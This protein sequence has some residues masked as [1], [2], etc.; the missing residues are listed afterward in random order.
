MFFVVSSTLTYRFP[1]SGTSNVSSNETSSL[2][3][4][5]ILT[6]STLSL[7]KVTSTMGTDS[8]RLIPMKGRVS[9]GF[10]DHPAGSMALAASPKLLEL[11]SSEF[12]TSE[13]SALSSSSQTG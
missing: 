12:G 4:T 10:G 5:M 2:S 3:L 9:D 13:T 6:T 11:N 8:G 7:S 1:P